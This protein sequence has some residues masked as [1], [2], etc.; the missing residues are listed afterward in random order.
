MLLKSV[1]C[2]EE[3]LTF[4]LVPF[5]P[6]ESARSLPAKSTRLIL[7]TWGRIK[8]N[9]VGSALQ[10][11]VP[12]TR[13]KLGKKLDYYLWELQEYNIYEVFK[14]TNFNNP[15]SQ[16]CQSVNPSEHL[17]C[18]A[19]W[20][21]SLHEDLIKWITTRD[22][23]CSITQ[24]PLFCRSQRKCSNPKW[25]SFLSFSDHYQVYQRN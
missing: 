23:V 10:I 3:I 15:K 25:F 2:D 14:N 5:A 13:K 16:I 7:L 22:I 18:S 20:N 9:L 12:L 1:K 17:H 8:C 11:F 24:Q 19:Q 6:V 21:V 4:S